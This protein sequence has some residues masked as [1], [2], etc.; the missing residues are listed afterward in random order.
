MAS[1]VL[2][3]LPIAFVMVTQNDPA[4]GV[5]VRVNPQY[6]DPH[7]TCLENS[8]IVTMKQH[9]S[10]SQIWFA[11]NEVSPEEL[12]RALKPKLA[13]R[14]NW[15]VFV[16]GDDSVPFADWMGAIDVIRALQAKPVILTPALRRQMVERCA[17]RS[18]PACG[19][20]AN[21]IFD[22]KPE[23]NKKGRVNEESALL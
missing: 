13:V 2:L 16:E 12:E 11:G 9:D 14:A 10:V 8:I 7:E 20:P 6:A 1:A 4:R 3:I 15:E 21:T 17:S 5:Y 22:K 18:V 23:T 19:M